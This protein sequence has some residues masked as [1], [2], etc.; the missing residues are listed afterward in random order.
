MGG[1]RFSDVSDTIFSVLERMVRKAVSF[2]ALLEEIRS[3]Y[4]REERMQTRGLQD[5]HTTACPMEEVLTV[6]QTIHDNDIYYGD[7]HNG[8]VCFTESDMEIS[9]V[10]IA[11][12]LDVGFSRLLDSSGETGDAAQRGV[13]P[14]EEGGYLQRWLPDAALSGHASKAQPLGESPAIRPDFLDGVDVARIGCSGGRL[15]LVNEI[16]ERALAEEP[17]ARYPDVR[18]MLDDI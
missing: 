10:G 8:N 7:L 15:K 9:R 1:A 14:D 18:A 17:E 16:L 3:G 4:S 13:P 6:L 12:L 11:R 5:I 2:D